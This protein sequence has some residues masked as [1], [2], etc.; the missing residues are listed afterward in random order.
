MIRKK[1]I[2]V[3]LPLGAISKAAAYE[4]MPGIGLHL[5]GLHLWW[6]RRDLGQLALHMRRKRRSSAGCRAV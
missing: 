3:A 5:R 2:G 6:A 4:K 1:L